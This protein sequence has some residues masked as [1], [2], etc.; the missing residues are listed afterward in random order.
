MIILTFKMFS[1]TSAEISPVLS[2][3]ES[4]V[5][6]FFF[7]IW[8][9]LCE[10]RGSCFDEGSSTDSGSW[11]NWFDDFSLSSYKIYVVTGTSVEWNEHGP[12]EG[13]WFQKVPIYNLKILQLFYN[14]CLWPSVFISGHFWDG[15]TAKKMLSKFLHQV[16]KL[17]SQSI[18]HSSN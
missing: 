7:F 16:L 18:Q 9:K 6:T 2:L 14:Y 17:F 15:K 1:K 4:L 3:L 10:G 5:T 8:V 11:T 13:I 12:F